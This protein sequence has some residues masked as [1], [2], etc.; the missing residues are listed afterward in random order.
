[1]NTNGRE[2]GNTFGNCRFP[3]LFFKS[4]AFHYLV[5]PVFF[6]SS[7]LLAFIGVYSRLNAFFGLKTG[8]CPEPRNTHIQNTQKKNA[9]NQFRVVCVFRG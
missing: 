3:H 4:M 7:F 5:N 6:A 2:Y 9:V 1:M 8:P